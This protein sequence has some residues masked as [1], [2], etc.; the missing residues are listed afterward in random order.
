MLSLALFH[1]DLIHVLLTSDNLLGH[2]CFGNLRKWLSIYRSMFYLI[3]LVCR[4]KCTIKVRLCKMRLNL[5]IFQAPFTRYNRLSDPL[6]YRLSTPFDNRFDNRLYRV[7]TNI[8]PVVK[9]CL[10]NR[11]YNPV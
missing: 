2:C 10:S 3:V 4:K 8:Q 1:V 5:V 9:P 6:S 11:L 7:Y